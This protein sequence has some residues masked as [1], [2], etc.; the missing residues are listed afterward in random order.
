MQFLPTPRYLSRGRVRI[1]VIFLLLLCASLAYLP[2]QTVA[3]ESGPFS[4]THI[5]TDSLFDSHQSISL[6]TLPKDSLRQYKIEFSYADS[7]LAKTSVLAER[8]NALAAINGG[9]FD[10]EHGGSVSYF[11]LH[12]SVINRTR[13]AQAKWAKPDRL[14]NGA[15]ILTKDSDIEIEPV[16]PDSF[17]EQSKVER[18]VLVVGPL[19]VRNSHRAR[20]PDVPF[21]RDNHPRSCLGIT[22]DAVVFIAIDGRS[23]NAGGMSLYEAQRYLLDLGCIDAINLD[24][25]GST[26]L[27][28]RTRGVINHPSDPTG[29]RPVANALLILRK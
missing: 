14:I 8:S 24:G 13:S 20:L 3:Q 28:T 26:T 16:E 25:G 19:L 9:F 27:W 29:E 12:D 18:G 21:T 10:M 11:E 23:E 17:Y 4:I 1:H 6:L 2:T 15:I 5:A 7:A 22:R